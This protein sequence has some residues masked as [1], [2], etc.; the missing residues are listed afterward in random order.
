METIKIKN[1]VTTNL[2]IV[3]GYNGRKIV[4]GTLACDAFIIPNSPFTI[5]TKGEEFNKMPWNLYRSIEIAVNNGIE[6][7]LY[8]DKF[9]QIWPVCETCDNLI[10]HT[11]H[12][13]Q[14]GKDY[15]IAFMGFALYALPAKMF[16]GKVEGDHVQIKV[17]ADPS[18]HGSSSSIYC[19]DENGKRGDEEKYTLDIK[20]DMVLAQKPYRYSRFGNFEDVLKRLGC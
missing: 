18:K 4:A 6:L 15:S 12:I 8:N 7:D 19:K 5:A 10:D 3:E 13:Y 1:N 17:H 14:D 16:E 11:Y 20:V 9:V 2:H